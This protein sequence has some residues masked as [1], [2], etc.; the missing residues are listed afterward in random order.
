MPHTSDRDLSVS[1]ATVSP[2]VSTDDICLNG[3]GIL[4]SPP[5]SAKRKRAEELLEQKYAQQQKPF[6]PQK[7]DSGDATTVSAC[8]HTSICSRLVFAPSAEAT[9]LLSTSTHNYFC[10]TATLRTPAVLKRARRSAGAAS[11]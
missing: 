5:K 3:N 11:T 6:R 10:L 2:R 1:I 8:S 7:V 9:L 4:Y